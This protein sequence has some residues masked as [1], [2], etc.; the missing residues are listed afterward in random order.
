MCENCCGGI[1]YSGRVLTADGKE[2]VPN[3]TLRL[4]TTKK[5]KIERSGTSNTFCEYGNDSFQLL[6]VRRHRRHWGRTGADDKP[7]SH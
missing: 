6:S 1:T 4:D 7:N 3:F 5:K 2:R